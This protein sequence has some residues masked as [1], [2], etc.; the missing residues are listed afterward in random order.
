M[1]NNVFQPY[2]VAASVP[3]DNSTDGLHSDNVQDA[4]DEI[5]NLLTIPR[6][7]TVVKAISIFA[8]SFFKIEGTLGHMRIITNSIPN[9]TQGLEIL[10]S[11]TISSDAR[12]QLNN[13]SSGTILGV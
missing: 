5:N 8:D 13:A 3:F 4:I 7:N 11:I 6:V 2:P 1:I 10:G 12:M 9:T